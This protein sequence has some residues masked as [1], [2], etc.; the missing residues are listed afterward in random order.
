VDIS[1]SIDEYLATK[2]VSLRWS[3]HDW[4]SRFLGQFE[5]WTIEH[6]LNDL[7]Q[8]TAGHVAQFI[9]DTPS[10]NTYTRHHRAQIVKG[11][12][13]W[14]AKDSDMGVRKSVVERIEM[15]HIQESEVEIFT[16]NDIAKLFR[17]AERTKQPFRNIAL[18]HILLDTGIRASELCFDA[19]RPHEETG[20]RMDGVFL[21]RR[22]EQSY[23]R[24]DGKGQK[25]RTIGLGASTT[26]ALRRYLN[27]ER[28]NHASPFVFLSQDGEPLSIRMLQQLLDHLGRIAGVSNVHPHRFRHT[29]AVNQLLAGT[30][31]M[32]LM[33]LMGH[34]TLDSTRIYIRAMSQMQ[35]RTSAISIVDRL[36]GGTEKRRPRR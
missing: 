15:P 28:N 9:A 14:C 13:S 7:S 6:Q 20:L 11:F 5:K 21:G 26:L 1:T 19:D 16:P 35:A 2:Q 18:L 31:D 17:A 33:R 32:V 29:F 25:I 12:L 10:H 4:Y 36:M 22:R 3:T 27:R 30:S 23:I 24:V 34:S 8:I